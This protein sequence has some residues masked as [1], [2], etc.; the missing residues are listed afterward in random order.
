MKVIKYPGIYKHFKGKYYATMGVSTPMSFDDIDEFCMKS[1]IKA[2]KLLKFETRYTETESYKG[3]HIFEIEGQWHH[4]TEQC[5][6]LLILY[7]SLCDNNGAY[8]RSY[9]IFM[10]EVDKEKYPNASQKYRFELVG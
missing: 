9:N 6:D 10:S 3:V 8:T 2:F 5:K 4:M 7:K 1:N